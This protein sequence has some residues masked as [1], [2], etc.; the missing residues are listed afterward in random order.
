MAS[1]SL[2]FWS[3]RV[4]L[5]QPYL[6]HQPVVGSSAAARGDAPSRCDGVSFSMRRLRMRRCASAPRSRSERAGCREFVQ[7]ARHVH[8]AEGELD[9]AT[10]GQL[11]I[12]D[13][14]VD[15]QAALTR[16]SHSHS[17]V[18]AQM[19]S[20][21]ARSICD[22]T[23]LLASV[24]CKELANDVQQVFNTC[25][26]STAPYNRPGS[27]NVLRVKRRRASIAHPF[28]QIASRHQTSNRS[29]GS[30]VNGSPP[31]SVTRNVSLIT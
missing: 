9:L 5:A 31:A 13:V 4:S 23:S 20:I 1:A 19:A 28:R 27:L 11:W 12:A 10:F 30:F 24:E 26:R 21:G 17:N 6:E 7:V 15:L 16:H 14:A 29:R 3:M 2:V 25:K 18:R 8:P 22:Q